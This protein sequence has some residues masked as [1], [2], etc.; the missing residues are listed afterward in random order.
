[1]TEKWREYEADFNSLNDEEIEHEANVSLNEIAEHEDWLEAI[2]SWVAAGRPRT[3]PEPTGRN[4]E[5]E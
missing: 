4:K 5:P 1:M 3:K 2:A